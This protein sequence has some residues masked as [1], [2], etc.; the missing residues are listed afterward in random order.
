MEKPAILSKRPKF[1]KKIPI[2]YP[3]LPSL[4]TFY[5]DISRIFCSGMITNAEYVKRLEERVQRYTGAKYSVAVSS[6]TSGLILV[7]KCLDLKGEVIL[8]SYTFPATAIAL[9]WNN[10]KPIFVDI[11]PATYNIDPQQVKKKITP[12]TKAIMATYVYGNPP[13][14]K[15]LQEIA[16]KYN[17]KLIF[18]AAHALGARYKGRLAGSFGTAE[19]FSLSPTKL[20][21]AGEGG[22]VT[23]NDE[24]L[25]SKLRIARNYGDPGNNNCEFL[26]LNARMPELSAILGLKTLEK[27]GGHLK[28]RNALAK[29]YQSELAGIPGI[30]FPQVKSG[31]L[32]TFKDFSLLID[33]RQFGLNRDE[34]RMA[35]EAENISTRTYFYPPVHQQKAFRKY[36]LLYKNKLPL[37]DYISNNIISLPMYFDLDKTTVKNICLCIKKAYLYNTQI[38]KHIF[39]VRRRQ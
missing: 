25:A 39:W 16:R 15:E 32:C 4:S 20:A 22:L 21:T 11:D 27:I 24:K 38:K 8:P 17:L 35:L 6:C 34:L 13:E 5:K 30:S 3:Y 37:T 33:S 10:L 26:G 19:V 31:N 9:A 29:I 1:K 28:K 18:D 23:T 7:L 14:I 2:S 36:H 12:K